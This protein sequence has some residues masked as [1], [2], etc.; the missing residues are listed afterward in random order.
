MPA[1]CADANAGISGDVANTTLVRRTSVGHRSAVRSNPPGYDAYRTVTS[2]REVVTAT[3]RPAAAELEALI[4][5]ASPA[6]MLLT[7]AAAA[8]RDAVRG[9]IRLGQRQNIAVLIA[10]DIELA[11]SLNADG[12]HIAA[13]QRRLAEARARLGAEKTVGASCRLFRHEAMVMGEGGADYIA[14]GE[15]W[16]AG[17]RDAEALAETIAWWAQIFELPCVGWLGAEDGPREAQQLVAAG[18]DFV[19]LT[20]PAGQESG[21]K[22]LGEITAELGRE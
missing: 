14:F 7:G 3:V 4:A 1:T 15:H 6:A 18:A 10:D 9:L 22:R 12:V 8:P 13:D 16:G 20:L 17:G 19:A 2:P 5:A 11:A 21:I